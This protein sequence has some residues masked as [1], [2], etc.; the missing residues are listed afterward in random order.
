MNNDL[1]RIA[2][3]DNSQVPAG[4]EEIGMLQ[5][6]P[7][8]NTPFILSF[9]RAGLPNLILPEYGVNRWRLPLDK[10]TVFSE[11]GIDCDLNVITPERGLYRVYGPFAMP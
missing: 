3:D 8:L 1:I 10:Y 9:N 4:W 7:G 11:A 5:G 6:T 2:D